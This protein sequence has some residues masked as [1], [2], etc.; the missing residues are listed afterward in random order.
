M[1]ETQIALAPQQQ[2]AQ[3]ITMRR[4]V[5]AAGAGLIPIPL[6]DA[7]AILGVQILMLRDIARVYEVEFKEQRVKPMVAALVGDVAVVG[8][9]KL[10]PGLGTFFGGASAAAAG[11]A[12][13][14]ALGKVFTGHFAQGGTLQDFDPIKSKAF[15]QKELE[16][17]K[18][19]VSNLKK[20]AGEKISGKPKGAAPPSTEEMLA[21]QKALLGEITALHQQVEALRAQQP[22]VSNIELNNLQ[23]VE[24]I[25][26]KIE[27]ALKAGGIM[28][29]AQLA[30]STPEAVK[31]ILG[32]A[33]GNFSLVNPDTWPQQAA[34]ATEGNRAALTNLQAALLAGKRTT[35]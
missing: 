28:D 23:L 15:F 20:K 30:V 18:E 19:V 34:L 3:D 33:E 7:A 13:T 10:V 27:V 6:V 25:G 8:L 14:Y 35:S 4:T 29:L 12:T 24:G 32:K 26:P 9:F 11:G 21:Q 5:Y 2:A 17:G 16:K 31:A 22:V 1:S